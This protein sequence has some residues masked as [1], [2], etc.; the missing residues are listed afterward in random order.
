MDMCITFLV[1]VLQVTE[2][3]VEASLRPPSPSLLLDISGNQGSEKLS[4]LTRVQGVFYNSHSAP[5][6]G[7]C[8]VQVF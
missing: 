5:Q 8:G 2:C 7:S 4:D 1:L 6:G 3:Q